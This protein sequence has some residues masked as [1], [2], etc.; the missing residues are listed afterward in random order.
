[1]NHMI[2]ESSGGGCAVYLCNGNMS[3]VCNLLVMF[4]DGDP[5]MQLT[6]SER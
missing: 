3:T 5:E 4:T 1:V 2:G 6:A